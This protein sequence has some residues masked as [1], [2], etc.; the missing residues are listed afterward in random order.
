MEIIEI[1]TFLNDLSFKEKVENLFPVSLKN[2]IDFDFAI[3]VKKPHSHYVEVKAFDTS[4]DCDG[5]A[6]PTMTVTVLI[7]TIESMENDILHKF[8]KY[9][10]EWAVS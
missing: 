1:E 3:K 9:I 10:D 4:Y 7:S 2:E 6:I 5:I 8:K